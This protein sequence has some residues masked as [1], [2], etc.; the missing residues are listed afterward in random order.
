VNRRIRRAVARGQRWPGAIFNALLQRGCQAEHEKNSVIKDSGRGDTRRFVAYW[1]ICCSSL[2]MA[3]R[4]LT[5]MERILAGG[6]RRLA[7]VEIAKH[8]A[9]ISPRLW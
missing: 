4:C 9:I 2:R 1:V 3:G 7:H 6:I 8:L 5:G